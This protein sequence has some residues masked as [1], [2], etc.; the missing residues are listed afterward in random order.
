MTVFVEEWSGK[1][2]IFSKIGQEKAGKQILNLALNI[3]LDVHP[4]IFFN[5]PNLTKLPKIALFIQKF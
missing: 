1:T 5:Q 4:Q 3:K 2:G